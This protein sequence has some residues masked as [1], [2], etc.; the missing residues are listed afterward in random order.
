M[1]GFEIHA[2]APGLNSKEYSADMVFSLGTP[3]HQMLVRALG[4]PS[5][6]TARLSD[7]T[8]ARV[9]SA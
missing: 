4:A 6:A 8:G 1:A 3:G 2:T 5:V 7:V 9:N